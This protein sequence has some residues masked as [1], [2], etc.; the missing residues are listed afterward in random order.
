[1]GVTFKVKIKGYNIHISNKK[2]KGYKGTW[3][4]LDLKKINFVFIFHTLKYH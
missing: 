2:P 3:P 1:L 4:I